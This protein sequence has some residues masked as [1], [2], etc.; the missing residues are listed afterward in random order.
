[1][2]IAAPDALL[3]THSVKIATVAGKT[4]LVIQFLLAIM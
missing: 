1:M 3:I 4:F 2:T